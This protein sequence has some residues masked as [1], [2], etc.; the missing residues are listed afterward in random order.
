MV[1]LQILTK[2]PLSHS[3][4]TIENHCSKIWRILYYIFRFKTQAI[5][6]YIVYSIYWVTIS[7]EG[8]YPTEIVGT[9][10]LNIE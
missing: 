5:S 7:E 3:M 6:I 4:Q 10:L 9:A 2:Y 1:R 8:L